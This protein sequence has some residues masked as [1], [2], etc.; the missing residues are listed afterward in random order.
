M[1]DFPSSVCL[2]RENE[3]F[4][5]FEVNHPTCR[6]RIALHGAQVLSWHPVGAAEVIYL[7]PESHY[8]EGKAIRGGIPLC[9]PWFSAHASDSTLPSH[10]IARTRF[11]NLESVRETEETVT[12]RFATLWRELSAIAEIIFGNTLDVRLTT[13]NV[14]EANLLLGGALHSYFQVSDISDI[15]AEGLEGS[16]YLDTLPPKGYKTQVGPLRITEEFDAIFSS[17]AIVKIIDAPMKRVIF[18]EKSGCPSTVVWNPW[19]VKARSLSDLP[20]EDYREFLC[21]EPAIV[22]SELITLAPGESSTFST[23]IRLEDHEK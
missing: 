17:D 12:F 4:P 20:D 18:I 19:I 5:I 6:A 2:S 23:K 7:S 16:T 3:I 21:V 14:G 1:N 8:M 13:V 10:G 15:S 11:W 22:N 9:W